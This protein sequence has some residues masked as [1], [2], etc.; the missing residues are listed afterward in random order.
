[1]RRNPK[2]F[3]F[4]KP[5]KVHLLGQS[6]TPIKVNALSEDLNPLRNRKEVQ[7]N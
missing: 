4:K 1:M 5:E 2:Y 7:M 3:E 6:Y